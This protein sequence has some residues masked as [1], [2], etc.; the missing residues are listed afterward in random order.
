M[1]FL[2][3]LFLVI[4]FVTL[5]A[6]FVYL[7]KKQKKKGLIAITICVISMFLGNICSHIDDKSDEPLYSVDLKKT[8]TNYDS[9]QR[10]WTLDADKNGKYT[11]KLRAN[12]DGKI[13]VTSKS[14]PNTSFKTKVYNVEADE[15]VKVPLTVKTGSNNS[16]ADFYIKADNMK[17]VEVF[18][19]NPNY[20]SVTPQKSLANLKT[21]ISSPMNMQNYQNIENNVINAAKSYN[22]IIHGGDDKAAM[23]SRNACQ[24]RYEA[25]LKNVH[26]LAEKESKDYKSQE[27]HLTSS[28]WNTLQNYQKTLVNYLDELYSYA[29]EVQNATAIIND[30]NP[31][32]TSDEKKNAQTDLNNEQNKFNAIKKEWQNQYNSIMNR[33]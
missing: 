32:T 9:F 31:H 26:N 28:D 13:T 12:K 30:D 11:L 17:T 4:A 22:D 2:S 25:Q 8:D 7:F 10:M 27:L 16:A 21:T 24:K 6:C 29:V 3:I 1:L 5:I 20:N 18:L 14:D 15:V 19:S 23:E 33:N